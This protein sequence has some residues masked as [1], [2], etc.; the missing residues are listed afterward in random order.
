MKQWHMFLWLGVGVLAALISPVNTIIAGIISP[1]LSS[2][3]GGKGAY[4]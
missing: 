1:V 3:T 2:V 4:V